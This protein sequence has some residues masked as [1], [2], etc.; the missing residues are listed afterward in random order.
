MLMLLAV[1]EVEPLDG[2]RLRVAFNDGTR[3]VSDVSELLWGEMFEPLCDAARFREV[4]LDTGMGTVA[5][6]NDAD[7]APRALY[8]RLIDETRR[9]CTATASPPRSEVRKCA[10]PR[11]RWASPGGSARYTRRLLRPQVAL[12][13]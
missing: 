8:E 9:P 6:P 7:V 4:F 13:S 11:L 2:F 10:R 3:G 1:T 12:R 5:W